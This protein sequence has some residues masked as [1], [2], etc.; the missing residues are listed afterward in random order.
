[1]FAFILWLLN[2]SL[3]VPCPHPSLCLVKCSQQI[4]SESLRFTSRTAGRVER[5]EFPAPYMRTKPA[6][7][8]AFTIR[9]GSCMLKIPIRRR[10][11]SLS[12]ILSSLGLFSVQ[13]GTQMRTQNLVP[14]QMCPPH[15]R[16]SPLVIE[17]HCQ[18]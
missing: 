6:V 18:N 4:M 17:L 9:P 10:S 11:P 12:G 5:R 1:M 3:F 13:V 15:S 16:I 2:F 14:Q 7:C 8:H